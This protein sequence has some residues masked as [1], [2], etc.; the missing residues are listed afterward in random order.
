[1]CERLSRDSPFSALRQIAE[2]RPLPRLL[3]FA[4]DMVFG[5]NSDVSG[6]WVQLEAWR[7][8]YE[9]SSLPGL[10]VELIAIP[11]N[12]EVQGDAPRHAYLEA[13]NAWRR[14]PR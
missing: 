11:G 13:E 2:V 4:G 12:H 10:G 6:T 14:I 7:G 1:M 8:V 5:Y 9:S 3:F